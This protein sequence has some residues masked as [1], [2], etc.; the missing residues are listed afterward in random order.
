MR[1]APALKCIYS[2]GHCYPRGLRQWPLAYEGRDIAG[3]CS[4]N[5][6][7][8]WLARVVDGP[9]PTDVQAASDAMT[10]RYGAI[11][12]M[13]RHGELV[14]VGDPVRR[15]DRPEI[16]P[17]VWQ[18]KDFW[19]D[20]QAGDV[21]QVARTSTDWSDFFVKRWRGVFL[22][23]R[24]EFPMHSRE[25]EERVWRLTMTMPA[26]DRQ[27]AV[28]SA[29]AQTDCCKWLIKIMSAA[30]NAR[31][32]ATKH[33][34]LETALQR[35]PGLSKRGFERAWSRSIEETGANWNLPGRPKKTSH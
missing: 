31:S 28:S 7:V 15:G 6:P 29:K 1:A 22:L 26:V 9:V 14:G 21:V 20:A 4:P 11:M 23:R 8:G 17:T 18:H 13:L 16:L 3:G 10:A 5:S 32:R 19:I 24:T 30:H 33:S 12:D 34:L 2:S 25:A 35:F 27:S